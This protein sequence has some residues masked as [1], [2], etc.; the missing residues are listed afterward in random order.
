MYRLMA[1]SV[2][3]NT[4]IDAVDLARGL[5][6]LFMIAAHTVLVVG[7]HWWNGLF[8]RFGN[9]EAM[10]LFS[11]VAGISAGLMVREPA[12]DTIVA[13]RVRLAARALV[14]LAVSFPLAL[15]NTRV[16]LILSYYALWFLC[17]I[18]FLRWSA[19]RLIIAAVVMAITAGPLSFLIQYAVHYLTDPVDPYLDMTLFRAFFMLEANTYNGM[20]GFAF[21]LLGYGLAR[22]GLVGNNAQRRRTLA[23]AMVGLGLGAAVIGVGAGVMAAG[24][25]A[26]QG[27]AYS[28]S[29]PAV[30]A[31]S[32]TEAAA[33]LAYGAQH[34]FATAAHYPAAAYAQQIEMQRRYPEDLR[35]YSVPTAQE[36]GTAG[37]WQ[38]FRAAVGKDFWLKAVWAGTPHS[39]SLVEQVTNWGFVAILMGGLILIPAR[40][41]R[42]LRW[43]IPFGKN[44]LTA[45]VVHVPLVAWAAHLGIFGWPLFY[46]LAVPLIG[47]AWVWDRYA[48]R[49]PME[50][51]IHRA[52]IRAATGE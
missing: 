9:V 5:S 15:V 31:A 28:G 35:H 24:H 26:Q 52:S 3:G 20:A 33:W 46:L 48:G 13:A 14:L 43:F 42:G 10:P 44:S 36:E 45:Y 41:L 17:L 23:T 47:F 29:V 37:C 49:M 40:V 27:R 7:P 8:A 11:L 16:I 6:I 22:A 50:A 32:D 34:P 12:A 21:I 38:Q 4:R 30:T 25:Y 19:R 51:L 39:G 1:D 18:P 2:S